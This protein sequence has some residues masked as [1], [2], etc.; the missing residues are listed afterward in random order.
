[1]GRVH[2][3]V[4]LWLAAC[5]AA[6]RDGAG[7]RGGDGPAP[8]GSSS[9][10]VGAGPVAPQ[11]SA[12]AGAPVAPPPREG[13]ALVRG[14]RGDVLYVA[15]EDRSAV[16]VIRL[17]IDNER[18][19]VAAPMPG[20]P[21]QALASGEEVLVTI[22]DPSMLLILA[23]SR[24][25]GLT[26]TG[27]VPLPA[28][29]WG[30][31][32]TPDGKTAVVTSAWAHQVSVVDLAA[33]TVRFSVDVGRE[34][35]GVTVRADGKAAYV[36]HLVSGTGALTKVSLEAAAAPTAIDLPAAPLRTPMDG[37]L[38]A[39]LGYCLVQS[40]D[41][42]RVF[43]GRHAI[44]AAGEASWFGAAAIDVLLVADERALAPTRK[45]A[46]IGRSAIEDDKLDDTWLDTP[47]PAMVQPRAMV[48][49]Q[50]TQTLV[51][52]SEGLHALFELEARAIDPA[53]VPVLQQPLGST[54]D[55]TEPAPTRCSA[56]SGVALAAD[57]DSAFV[58]CRASGD[59][60]VVDLTVDKPVAAADVRVVHLADDPL[61]ALA[62]RGRRVFYDA[63]DPIT[64]GGLACAGC[65]PEGR[66]DGHVWME[67]VGPMTSHPI[68]VG[69]RGIVVGQP[70]LAR[71]TP[72]LAG[73][74]AAPGPYGW[75]AQNDDLVARILE[76]VRLHRW[77]N[78]PQRWEHLETAANQR[79]TALAEFLRTGL[80]APARPN[81]PL[82]PEE[83]RG[84]ELFTSPQTGCAGCH[85]PQTEYTN[86]IAA[87]MR[88]PVAPAGFIEDR[89]NAFKTPSLFFVGGTPPYYHD[90]RARTLEEV[91]T[92]NDDRM[93]KTNHLSE[94]DRAALVAFLRTL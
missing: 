49:R 58:W 64:S 40:P 66:D 38:A 84:K 32:V 4:A 87:P 43:A 34:P 55:P 31:A 42:K 73:R 30:V 27:R 94:P 20:R 92:G 28:D 41:G 47:L 52:V 13:G 39:S 33:K 17:P 14:A 79:A 21:A 70:A 78:P 11:G 35:R 76:G 83:E 5:A 2:L 62:A 67:V 29:A 7:D 80:V 24:D 90:G 37:T 71:Q 57:E 63:V 91:V 8:S 75:H 81:R 44:G 72:M 10:G 65:H 82:T 50:K 45:G 25:G 18:P 1:M 85:V 6:C 59:V 12:A 61:P 23:P 77:E 16:R 54:A 93:G 56:P 51:V 68:F 53:I 48:Y 36:S 89:N 69:G 3:A 74:V 60:A 88:Q 26:E 9:A 46:P 19:S 22:R 15:D 86:R